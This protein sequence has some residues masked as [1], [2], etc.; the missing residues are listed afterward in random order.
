MV[1]S[2]FLEGR[3]GGRIAVDM[4]PAMKP[5]GYTLADRSET[6]MPQLRQLHVVVVRRLPSKYA[7]GSI[8]ASTQ[9]IA[10]VRGTFHARLGRGYQ[11]LV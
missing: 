7:F 3:A 9:H 11:I 5:I 6:S 4:P 10:G 1:K 2:A 8:A